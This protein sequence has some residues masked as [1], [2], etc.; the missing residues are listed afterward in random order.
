MTTAVFALA[1]AWKF[2][3]PDAEQVVAMQWK[4]VL[5]SPMSAEVR[6]EI[7]L[8]ATPVLA[9]INFIEGIDSVVWTP[10]LTVLEGSFDVQRLKD[11]AVADGGIVVPY[12]AMEVAG[13]AEKE[14]TV[15][16]L[17]SSIV[18]LGSSA[19]VRSAIDR[20]EKSS[21]V[22]PPGAYDLWIRTAG[23][24]FVRH[25][26]G[27][28]IGDRILVSSTL[29]YATE[30]S[31]RA[32]AGNA[33]QFQLTGSSNGAETA[34]S[35]ALSPEEFRRRQWRTTLESLHTT[36]SVDPPR[37]PGVIRIHGLDTGVK[38]IHLK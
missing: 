36:T 15:I 32:A 33:A 24:G 18:L 27:V 9:G 14:G 29:R 19:T 5:N 25:E 6:R 34:L 20:A 35:G 11:M 22:G 31:A 23:S 28:R 10:G 16:G 38:E 8:N 30:T 13:P 37:T 7:P 26:F 12:K 17:S 2:I 1:L 3:A 21:A 4:R